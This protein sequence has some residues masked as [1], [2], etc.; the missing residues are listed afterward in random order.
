MKIGIDA[1]SI[2]NPEKN[3]S[4]GVGHHTYQLIKNLLKLDQRNNYE[5]F[6][7][8]RV[9]Q[10]DVKKFSKPNVEIKYFPWSDYKKYLPGAY[11]EILGLATLSGKKFDVLH[12]TSPDARVPL[13]Y[14][15]KVVCTFQDLAV[16]KHPKLFPATGRLKSRYNRRA[17]AS[18]ADK[19]IAVSENTKQDLMEFFGVPEGKIKVIHNGVDQRFFQDLP[20]MEAELKKDL[21]KKFNIDRDYVLFV[22]T[23]EPVK[24]IARLL[25]AFKIFK[26]KEIDGKKS[27]HM[28]VLAGKQGW[29]ANEYVQTA[30]NLGLEDDVKFL[31]Y[32]EGEDLQKLFKGTKLF[33]MPSLYEGFGTT[34]LEA[35][36]SKSACLVS[37]IDPLRKIAG[38]AVEYANPLDVEELAQKIGELAD[39]EKR[40]DEMV[41]KG[42]ERARNFSWEK[43]ARETLDVYEAMVE[44]KNE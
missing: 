32:V 23:L 7:D 29:M 28:L 18:R 24:N 26:E 38:D 14:R 27:D 21:N 39:D 12:I 34:V 36:A 33:V 9:R 20:L 11:S 35:M 6:F 16:Y 13:G 41:I 19:L 3:P 22:G 30:K 31:G 42:I 1:R 44:G 2:L 25:N 37:D 10:K 5:L 40:K 17:M 43:C 15:G 8:Y 4:I